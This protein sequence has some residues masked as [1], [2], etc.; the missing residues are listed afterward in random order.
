MRRKHGAVGA[1][2]FIASLVLPNIPLIHPVH[3]L[4]Y[5]KIADVLI[6][7]V[8]RNRIRIESGLL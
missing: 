2:D 6:S 8:Y 1:F 5:S 7:R 3:A 4:D